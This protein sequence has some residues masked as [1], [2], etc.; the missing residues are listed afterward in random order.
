VRKLIYIAG[1]TTILAVAF[2]VVRQAKPN[3]LSATS[4]PA[5]V[6]APVPTEAPVP[7]VATPSAATTTSAQPKIT[8]SQHQIEV[9]LAPGESTAKDI[10]FTSNFKLE[11]VA[12]EA[13]PGIA[14]LLTIQPSSIANVISGSPNVV[15]VSFSIPQGITPGAY[16]GTIHVRIGSQTL[17]QTLKV[18]VNVWQSFSDANL[19]LSFEFPPLDQPTHLAVT[20][21]RS[22]KT[23]VD[24]QVCDTAQQNC[25]SE[26][27]LVIYD[28]P[29]H[30]SL[31]N[32]FEQNVDSGGILAANGTFQQQQLGNGLIALVL[33]RPVPEQYA[34]L[35]GP[36]EEAYALSPTGDRVLSIAQSQENTMFNLGFSQQ[37]ITNLL[38]KTLGTA[39]F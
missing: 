19:G 11:N 5:P 23:I 34:Q 38:I 31:L 17:P 24:F 9:I 10:M 7:A 13:V 6:S 35:D 4:A 20:N 37:S 2:V 21:P 22:G 18:A 33:V 30:L 32:W 39:Q 27:G 28:N 15:H 12:I 1:L 36:V 3:P 29:A 16:E 8:W 25:F 26:F 14:G